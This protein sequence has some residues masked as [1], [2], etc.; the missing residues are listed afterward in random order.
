M[1]S[2]VELAKV[3]TVGSSLPVTESNALF[4]EVIAAVSRRKEPPLKKGPRI[5]LDG[6][7]VDNIELMKIVEDSGRVSSLTRRAT[8]PGTLYPAQTRGE[9]RS[10][11]WLVGISTRST[12]PK[13]TE[14]T[15]QEPLKETRRRAS[16]TSALMPGSSKP[17]AR[18]FMFTSFA[19][20]SDSRCPQERPITSRSRSSSSYRGPLFGGNDRPAENENPGFSRDDRLTREGGSD[21]G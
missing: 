4:D 17:T 20:P 13:P 6:P 12:A 21:N 8:A 9:I 15:K 19:I 2:G 7:C 11:P 14:I 10:R 1:L 5:L 18:F 16:E 3:L